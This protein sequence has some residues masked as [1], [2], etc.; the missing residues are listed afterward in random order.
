MSDNNIVIEPVYFNVEVTKQDNEV[1]IASPGPQGLKGDPG[2]QGAQG[3]QG[4]SGTSGGSYAFEQQF[5]STSWTVVHNLGYRPAITVQDYF[6]NTI[7]GDINHID[8]ST[9]QLTFAEAVSGY[10]YLS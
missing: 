3:P 8:T 1:T 9:V 10:A 7:E 2:L 6:K 5:N 4:P